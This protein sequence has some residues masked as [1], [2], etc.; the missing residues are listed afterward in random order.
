MNGQIDALA[1]SKP[2]L[3]LP[4]VKLVID[5]RADGTI[6]L[7][8]AADLA[9]EHLTLPRALAAQ[10]LRNPDKTHLAERVGSE[11]GWRRQS[12]AEGKAAADAVTQWLL[13]RQIEPGRPVL[14]LSGNSIA[15]STIRNGAMAASVPVCP[16]SVNYALMGAQNDY[17]RLRYAL[18]LVRP[19]VI[20]AESA[21]FAAAASAIAPAGVPVITRDPQAFGPEAVAYDAV[22]ATAVSDAVKDAIT[23]A[24]PDAP[25]AYMLTSGSTGRP[26]AVVHTQRM[27]MSSVYQ[28]YQ[29]LGQFAGWDGD[30]LDWLPWNHV[31]GT[32]T[33]FS[34]I[35]FG[36]SLHIDEGKPTPG[37]F[38]ETLRNLREVPVSYFTNVPLGFAMLADAAEKDD[39]LRRA[40][41]KNLQILLY[42]GAGLPQ[43]LYDRLQALSEKTTGRRLF[44][45]TGYGSTETTSGFMS[46]HF[47]SDRVGVG[48]PMPGMVVKL[49]P[50]G[51]H[52]ELRVKGPLVMKGYLDAPQINASAFDDEG[53]YRMGDTVGLH[54]PDDFTQGLF[55]AGRIAEEFKL[56][57]G[58]FV[59]GGALRVELVAALSPL[60]SD[61]LLCGEGRGAVG[62]LA[63][64]AAGVDTRDLASVA[65]RLSAHNAANPGSSTRVAR[66]A[67]LSEPPSAGA[68]ELSDKGS[69]N[70]GAALRRRVADVERLYAED[71]GPDVL[72]L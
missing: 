67:Y 40:I 15:H 23:S 4:P 17:E 46:I 44:L 62:V 49:V 33:A 13:D 21:A 18:E 41:F 25:A 27:I 64:P 66:F 65:S 35:T 63:W 60:V 59:R 22:I 47:P 51:E 39:E 54:D 9:I 7:Q 24:D 34:A 38:T 42:G 16:L 30:L 53:F 69:I 56:D 28:G 45:T 19:A 20:F 5:H 61:L 2:G 1:P 29:A 31:S 50:L 26:K 71:P 68:H 14:I 3:A 48:L 37:A 72:S 12:F 6:L 43:P 58:T 32:V 52:Y 57:S 8:S 55:F 36:G 11:P 10:A 70:Q